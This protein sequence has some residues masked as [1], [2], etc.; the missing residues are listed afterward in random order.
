MVFVDI[1]PLGSG[2]RKPNVADP[3]DPDPK[4]CFEM[5]DTNKFKFRKRK[6]EQ[7]E[8]MECPICL[9]TPRSG[10]IYSCRK[11]HIICKVNC[12]EKTTFKLTVLVK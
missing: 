5:S 12:I 2:S 11:G 9:D 3:K 7:L 10:P 1:S 8:W 6:I 4:H